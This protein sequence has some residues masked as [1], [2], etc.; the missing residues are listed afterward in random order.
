M[1]SW[2]WKAWASE[3]P[4]HRHRAAASLTL[5]LGDDTKNEI[6]ATDLPKAA[7]HCPTGASLTIDDSVLNRTSDGRHITPENGQVPYDCTLEN[8]RQLHRGDP[9]SMMESAD[10]GELYA[11]TVDNANAAA[12]GSD[13]LF[14]GQYC[15]YLPLAPEN[16]RGT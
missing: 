1:P 9:L 16:R 12:I 13:Y 5:V 2:S 11:W 7:L 6:V 10:P 15:D 4:S 3:R 8:G 14:Q